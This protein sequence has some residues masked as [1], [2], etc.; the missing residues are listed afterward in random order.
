MLQRRR[1]KLLAW[2][3]FAAIVALTL[4]PLSLRQGVSIAPAHVEHFAAYAV[5]GAL[6][7]VAY[8]RRPVMLIGALVLA[9]AVLEYGQIFVPGR[10]ARVADFI[11]K[12]AGVSV[13]VVLV[14]LCQMA[15]GRRLRWG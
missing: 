13:S 15:H 10:D 5:L 14:R 4:G 8:P 3:A 1:S 6:F 12:A 2:L 7:L 11:V 9:A